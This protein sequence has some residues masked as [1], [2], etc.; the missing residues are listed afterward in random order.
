[1]KKILILTMLAFFAGSL[2]AAAPTVKILS[3]SGK[4]EIKVPGGVRS[5]ATE[6]MDIP[7][8]SSISTGFNASMVFLFNKNKISV[9]SLTR[10]TLEDY[11]EKE[12]TEATSLK[13]ATGKVRAEVKSTDG[14]KVDFTVTSPVATASVRGTTF[15]FDGTR[16]EVI[17]GMVEV[18]NERGES[19]RVGGGETSRVTYN[20]PPANPKDLAEM[21]VFVGAS[22][23]PAQTIIPLTEDPSSQYE[24]PAPIDPN[25]GG[26]GT[27]QIIVN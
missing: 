17:E 23:T 18:F 10:M 6:G 4:V 26:S 14:R 8:K 20:A 15:E 9:K 25:A 1:M 11:V 13:L 21:A 2:W 19:V 27:I 12:N 24:E 22:T 16:T 3:L 7:L 5:A